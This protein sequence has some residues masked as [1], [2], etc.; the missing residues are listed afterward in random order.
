[1]SLRLS[2]KTQFVEGGL[3][4]LLSYLDSISGWV[5]Y[6]EITFLERGYVVRT[7]EK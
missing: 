5:N 2:R 3:L 6:C 7:G 1:V 4:D